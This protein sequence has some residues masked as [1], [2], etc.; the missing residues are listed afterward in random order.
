MTR[1]AKLQAV[2]PLALLLTVGGAEIA[3]CALSSHPSSE[4]LWFLNVKVFLIFQRAHYVVGDVLTT[5]GAQFFFVA[6]PIFLLTCY[7][8]I[9]KRTFPLALGSNLSFA[10]A[11]LLLIWWN[12]IEK[13]ASIQASLTFISVPSGAGLYTIGILLGTCLLSFLISHLLYLHALRKPA[14]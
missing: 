2:G 12:Q 3:A 14:H 1:L 13:S 5:P 10:Y 7:G 11:W 4:L 8:M 6:L 9:R